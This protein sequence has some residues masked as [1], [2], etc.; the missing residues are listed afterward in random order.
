[1]NTDPGYE[2]LLGDWEA[3][4][5]LGGGVV[6]DLVA[7]TRITAAFELEGRVSGSAGCNRYTAAFAKDGAGIE[8]S[9]A[10]T[11]RMFCAAPEGVMEQEA[12][13]LALLAQAASFGSAGTVLELYGSDGALLVSYE[14]AAL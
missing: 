8:I 13:Y 4:G 6:S 9:S 3:T 5:L 2:S 11:T 10:A 12:T 7:G 14:R 1:M